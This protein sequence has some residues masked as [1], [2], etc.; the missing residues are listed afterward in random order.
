ALTQCHGGVVLQ[1]IGIRRR[2]A[3]KGNSKYPHSVIQR[4]TRAEVGI[5][6]SR[7]QDARVSA[8]M[9]I[10]ANVICQPAWQ[11]GRV[12]NGVVNI[13]AA[14]RTEAD[15]KFELLRVPEDFLTAGIELVLALIKVRSLPENLEIAIKT[16]AKNCDGGAHFF[17][18]RRVSD[19]AHGS[20]HVRAE[21][22]VI[23]VLVTA[24]ADAG[25]Q[26]SNAGRRVAVDYL[27][28]LT[29]RTGQC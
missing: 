15:G 5:V 1:E 21:I 28:R 27:F 23:D 10:H 13:A 17:E 2:A 11:V 8:L 9:A 29:R 20:A 3:Q 7:L 24:G 25:S 6:F 16:F 26:I 18:L 12:D 14:I 4:R 22:L 19:P